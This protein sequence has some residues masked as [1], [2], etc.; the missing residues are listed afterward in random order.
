M[1]RFRLILVLCIIYQWAIG[2]E[3]PFLLMDSSIV[4]T[5]AHPGMPMGKT[6]NIAIANVNGSINSGSIKYNN[7]VSKNASGQRYLDIAPDRFTRGEK[8]H[9]SWA[10]DVH[11][12]DLGINFGRFGLMAGHAFKSFGQVS[13]N[14]D[15][16]LLYAQ[17]NE[18]YV[19]QTLNL[20]VAPNIT[21]LNEVYLGGQLYTKSFSFGLK[22]KIL[23]GTANSYAED[24]DM[25][26]YTDE[27]YY[28]LT[29][30]KNYTL[31]SSSLVRYY[32]NDSITFDL[33]QFTLDNFLYNNSGYAVDFGM[34]GKVT[35][36]IFISFGA[37]DIGKI[38][39]DF[40]PRK[41]TSNGETTFSGYDIV[42][43]LRDSTSFSISDTLSAIL[44]VQRDIENYGT[45]LKGN[46]NLGCKYMT[47]KWTLGGFI[48]YNALYDSPIL[49]AT[50]SAIR[51]FK[52]LDL[53]VSYSAYSHS[54]N[55]LGMMLQVKMSPVYFYLSTDNL[56][57]LL[58]PE[59]INNLSGNFGLASR[60]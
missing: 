32:E 3:V 37:T 31:H 11:S 13:F 39:W 41:Y 45:T 46:Y 30:K 23:Y 1:Q 38:N 29:L 44:D 6:I 53:G 56:F 19:G 52:F 10:T 5:Y 55:N 36:N 57:S 25:S 18:P 12:L 9:L 4:S 17:G 33:P 54:Y 59:S 35:D 2:Q 42:E 14:S 50:V 34:Y 47:K 60:F 16:L 22:A 51:K 58:N 28:A 24:S 27:A 40:T 20:S 49:H 21:A 15:L 8:H 48:Q 43:V 7:L 26:L